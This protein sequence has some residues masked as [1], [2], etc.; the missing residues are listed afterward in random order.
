MSL[1]ER[2]LQYQAGLISR[3]ELQQ[4]LDFANM[5]SDCYF[6]TY[7]DMLNKLER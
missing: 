2:A 3:K 7:N 1:A 5:G 6:Y 4:Y